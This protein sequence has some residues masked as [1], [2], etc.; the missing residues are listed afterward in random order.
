MTNI[1]ND[2]SCGDCTACC[3]G[4]LKA[5]INGKKIH[6]GVGCEHASGGCGIYE[7]RPVRPCRTFMCQWLLN[8]NMPEWLKPSRSKVILK[9]KQV[10]ER[11]SSDIPAI[12]G[13][14]DVVMGTPRFEV[15]VA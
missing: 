11:P 7:T 2:R 1:A 12:V 6:P 9:G 8:P 13:S 5:E 15:S 10:W 14:L 4:W 3:D